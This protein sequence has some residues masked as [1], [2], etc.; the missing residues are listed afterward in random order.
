MMK[1][2]DAYVAV[3]PVS[4]LQEFEFLDFVGGFWSERVRLEITSGLWSCL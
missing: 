4:I 2:G 1:A 3:L